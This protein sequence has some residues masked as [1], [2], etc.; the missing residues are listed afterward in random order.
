MRGE[1]GACASKSALSAAARGQRLPNWE[2]AWEFVRVLAVDMLGRDPADA[3][4]EWRARWE[5][6]RDQL[7]ERSDADSGGDSDRDDGSARPG[8]ADRPKLLRRPIAMF[9]SAAVAI[10]L[11]GGALL[12]FSPGDP[13]TG[14][15]SDFVADVTCPMGA[16]CAPTPGSLRRGSCAT[17]DPS[18]GSADISS[19]PA[20]SGVLTNA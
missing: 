2:T 11:A 1:Y 18:D 12:Y 13:P 5:H 4:R 3:E 15:R 19:G 9:G 17:P 6:A 14:D 8:V 10:L 16:R 20:R 7:A